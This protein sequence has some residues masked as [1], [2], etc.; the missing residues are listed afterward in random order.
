MAAMPTPAVVASLPAT[1]EFRQSRLLRVVAG[2]V[3]RRRVGRSQSPG[4]AAA[5]AG[6]LGGMLGHGASRRRIA[7]VLNTAYA[8]GLLS[9]ETFARR[10]DQTLSER[11]T[12]SCWRS[13]GVGQAASW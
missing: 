4:H 1:I 11:Q 8:D 12:R 7:R 10:L 3:E 9:E 13:T 5:S 2:V 6:D